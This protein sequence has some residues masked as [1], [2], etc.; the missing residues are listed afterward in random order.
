MAA[1]LASSAGPPSA[2]AAPASTAA[3]PRSYTIDEETFVAN[4]PRGLVIGNVEPG[5]RIQ[6]FARSS[7]RR[8]VYG[9]VQGPEGFRRCGWIAATALGRRVA[10][11][12]RERPCP[13]RVGDVGQAFN[14]YSGSGVT[15]GSYVFD[16]DRTCTAYRNIDPRTRRG[17][18]PQPLLAPRFVNYR[19]LTNDGRYALI[20]DVT[21]K[22]VRRPVN[23]VFVEAQCVARPAVTYP[24]F[25]GVPVAATTRGRYLIATR[26]HRVVAAHGPLAAAVRPEPFELPGF[27][28]MQLRGPRGGFFMP[29]PAGRLDFKARGNV[30][31][32]LARNLTRPSSQT[33]ALGERFALATGDKRQFL[34][35]RRGTADTRATRVGRHERFRLRYITRPYP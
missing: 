2:H 6:V 8:F 22:S 20:R 12:R 31:T 4:R 25:Y 33:V 13:S 9:R 17:M 5:W 35:V 7:S 29:T 23:W 30:P 19:Y 28:A 32:G 21:R 14:S 11:G 3:A 18:H 10:T 15:D 34:S 24:E 27:F 16:F 26:G 1:A